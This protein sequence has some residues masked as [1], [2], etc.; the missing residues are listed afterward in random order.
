MQDEL[1]EHI[2]KLSAYEYTLLN[3][4]CDY[5]NIKFADFISQ[6]R[7]RKFVNARKVASYLLTQNKYTYNDTGQVISIIPKDHTTIIYYIR[8]ANEHIEKEPLFKNVVDSVAVILKDYSDKFT[9][10]KYKHAKS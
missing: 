1:Q 7:N 10:K 5:S 6:K 8:M 4:I 9:S 3:T 2:E